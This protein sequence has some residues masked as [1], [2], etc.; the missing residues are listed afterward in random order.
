[1]D[2]IVLRKQAILAKIERLRKDKSEAVSHSGKLQAQLAEKAAELDGF[3]PL[4][5]LAASMTDTAWG[6]LPKA[7]KTA[8]EPYRRKG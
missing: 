5:E 7:M 2:E 4:I 8:L 1:M 3:K 6:V